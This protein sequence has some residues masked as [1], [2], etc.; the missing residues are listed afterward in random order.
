MK[1]VEEHQNRNIY[2]ISIIYA[3][4]LFIGNEYTFHGGYATIWQGILYCL[5]IYFWIRTRKANS[6]LQYRIYLISSIL[7]FT[8]AFVGGWLLSFNVI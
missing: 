2:I 8:I 7:S 5:A 1:T 3:A 6:Q 4:I